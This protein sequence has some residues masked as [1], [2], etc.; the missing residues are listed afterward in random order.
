LII[1][2]NGQY[3]KRIFHFS[4][5]FFKLF[6]KHPIFS[7]LQAPFGKLHHNVI[8]RNFLL[9]FHPPSFIMMAIL[10]IR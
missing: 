7:R 4:A 1:T 10:R 2:A 6:S 5:N 9:Q 3:V 8:F